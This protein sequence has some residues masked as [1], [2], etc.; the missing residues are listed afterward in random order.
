MG[1]FGRFPDELFLF[2]NGR[3]VIYSLRRNRP[4]S[5]AF[6][7]SAIGWEVA[8]GRRKHLLP[9]W[10]SAAAQ[11]PFLFLPPIEIRRFSFYGEQIDS[12]NCL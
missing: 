10:T 1:Y 2:Q 11:I 5:R 4:E 6:A 7:L 3:N 12:E 9:R 8:Y